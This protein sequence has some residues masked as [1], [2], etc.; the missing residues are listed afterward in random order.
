M[1]GSSLGSSELGVDFACGAYSVQE[2]GIIVL[3]A[4]D[5]QGKPLGMPEARSGT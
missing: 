1:H 4:L 5:I 3:G 2:F